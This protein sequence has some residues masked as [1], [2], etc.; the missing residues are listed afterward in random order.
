MNGKNPL[1]IVL[2]T[3]LVFSSVVSFYRILPTARATYVEG[4]ITQDT[5]WTLVDSPFIISNNIVVLSGVTLTIEPGVQVRFG[6]NFTLAVNGRIIADGKDDRMIRF[7]SDSLNASAGDWG[8]ILINGTDHSSLTHC[9][10]EYG[11]NGVTLESGSLILQNSLVRFNS[12]GTVIAGGDATIMNDEITNNTVCGVNIA[13]GQVTMQNNVISANGDG[14]VLAGNLDGN[15]I[16]LQNN[17]MQN[18]QSG[19]VLGA[20]SY[21]NTVIVQN[22][23]SLNVDGFRVMSNTSTYIT[24]NY[25][26]NNTNGIYYENGVGHRAQFNDIYDNKMG[27]DVSST[28]NVSATYNYWGDETGPFHGYLNPAGKGNE[29]G[30]NGVNL[31]FIFFLSAPIDYNNQAPTSLLQTDKTLVA[32]SQYVTFIGANSHDDGRVDKYFYDFGDGANSGWTTLSLLNHTYS[33]VG[34]YLATLTVMDDFGVLSQNPTTT[35]I[36]VRNL[37]PLTVSMTLSGS[38]V[39]YNGNV[40]VTVYVS[41]ES[42]AAA[43]AAVTLLSAKGG[44]FSLASGVT[45]SNGQFETTFTAPNVTDTT[46]VRL[47]A[48]ASENGY[49]DGS[50]YTYLRVLPLLHIRMTTEPAT[51][52]SEATVAMIFNVTGGLGQPVANASLTAAVDNGT[53]LTS[54]GFMGADGTLTLNYTAPYTLSPMNVTITASTQETGFTDGYNQET[55]AVLQNVLAA[56]VTPDSSSIVSEGTTNVAVLVTSDTVPILK[57][58]VTVSGSVGNFTQAS[59]ITDS[60][61]IARFAFTAPQTTSMV[62]ATI[63]ATATKSHYIDGAGQNTISIMPRVLILQLTA[64]NYSTISEAN[65]SITAR[66]TYNLLPVPDVS[67][68]VTSENGGNFTQ[69]TGTT[70]TQGFAAFIFTAPQANAPLGTVITAVGAKT[71][72]VDGQDSFTLLVN[73]GNISVQITASSY[74]TV[75]GSNVILTVIAVAGSNPVVGAQVIV[76]ASAGNFSYTSSY[77]DSNGTCSFEF[78]AP[79]TTVQLPVVFTANVTKNGYIGNGNQTTINVVPV[80]PTQSEGG[81]PWITMLLI[82]VP[83]VIA[84]VVVVL[85]KRKVIVVSTGAEDGSA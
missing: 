60:Y 83:V 72:Y 18:N 40:T 48:G 52:K 65:V 30:G 80:A 78:S 59:G 15:I 68:T 20:D 2:T 44:S 26:S 62:N 69:T 19:I 23:V 36:T 3:L 7:T 63:T 82:I 4:T 76:S 58:T 10:I 12:N 11:I 47:I 37:T 75:P 55:I 51:V 81:L 25:I 24:R 32:P 46:D 70:D 13:G 67:V 53:L 73:P 14:V 35:M 66:V 49:A 1:F 22:N 84:V 8:T 33:T 27:M 77:T 29:V 28:A 31:L 74:A 61:G 71:G 9:I 21:S 5:D 17:V 38:V 85:I 50:C 43:N 57:A 34:T 56:T 42:G 41:T 6:E 16:I 45:D 54:S 64:Q 79:V 39:D